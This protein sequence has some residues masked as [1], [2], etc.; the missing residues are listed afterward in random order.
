MTRKTVKLNGG[1]NIAVGN[2]HYRLSITISSRGSGEE[3]KYRSIDGS[4]SQSKQVIESCF[5][6]CFGAGK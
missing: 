6:V 1:Y 2:V 3:R 4:V 5:D